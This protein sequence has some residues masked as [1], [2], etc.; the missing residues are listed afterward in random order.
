[1]VNLEQ[2]PNGWQAHCRCGWRSD[3]G[4]ES[5]MEV[6]RTEHREYVHGHTEPEP[7]TPDATVTYTYS[8][9]TVN[10]VMSAD[11]A[12]ATL[13]ITLNNLRQLVF[14]KKL[15]VAGRQGRKTFYNTNEVNAL[16]HSRIKH[17]ART[18]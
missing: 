10:N 3:F 8:T 14:K 15:T 2:T 18:V 16:A 5:E 12:A 1:M 6:A 7:Q 9:N 13:G 11:E 4:T 17:P